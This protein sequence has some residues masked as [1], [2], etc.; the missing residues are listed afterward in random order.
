MRKGNPTQDDLYW[1]FQ[2]VAAPLLDVL[3]RVQGREETPEEISQILT[4]GHEALATFALAEELG[5]P[6]LAPGVE[7]ARATLLAYESLMT[8]GTE[9]S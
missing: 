3:Q 1:H 2:A 7:V 8:P 5:Y 4:L 9:T 6:P